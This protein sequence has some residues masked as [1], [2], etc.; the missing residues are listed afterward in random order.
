M[1]VGGEILIFC[2]NKDSHDFQFL[3][4]YFLYI[5]IRGFFFLIS[6]FKLHNKDS[7]FL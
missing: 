1:E 7:L 4:W 6:G 5:S 2:E 3:C